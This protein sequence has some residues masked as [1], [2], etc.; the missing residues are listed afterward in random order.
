M[1]TTL[2]DFESVFPTLVRD[3]LADTASHRLPQNATDW[4]ERVSR[5][6]QKPSVQEELTQAF[7]SP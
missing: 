3:I 2:K 5:H 6:P 7:A 1:P 4:L